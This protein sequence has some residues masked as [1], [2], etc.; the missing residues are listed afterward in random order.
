VTLDRQGRAA[1]QL[2]R[3]F[4]PVELWQTLNY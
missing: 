1:L 2:K 3:Y 4:V